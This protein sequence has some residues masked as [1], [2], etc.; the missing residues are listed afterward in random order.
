[1]PDALSRYAVERSVSVN[2]AAKGGNP[3]LLDLGE[4]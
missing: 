4:A 3:A 2:I 1:M